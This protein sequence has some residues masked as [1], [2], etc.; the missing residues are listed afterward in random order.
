MTETA[1]YGLRYLSGERKINAIKLVRELTRRG[2]AECKSIVD[3]Q[4][5]FARGLEREAAEAIVARFVSEAGSEIELIEE[6]EH[7]YAFDLR[8]PQ[9]GDQPLVRLRWHGLTLAWERGRLDEWTGEREDSFADAAARDR[10]IAEQRGRWV[11]QGLETVTNELDLVRRTSAREL[12]FEQAIRETGWQEDAAIV[13]ADWLQRQGDPRGIVAALDLARARH[14]NQRE[15]LDRALVE[16]LEQH[17][18]HLFGPLRGIE[19]SVRLQ[20]WAGHVIRIDLDEYIAGH[21]YWRSGNL[22]ALA[23]LLGLPICAC[24]RSLLINSDVIGD[25]GFVSV[26]AGAD[27]LLLAGLRELALSSRY[28]VDTFDEWERMPALERLELLCGPGRSIRLPALRELKLEISEPDAV[29]ETLQTSELPRLRELNLHLDNPMFRGPLREQ[30]SPDVLTELLDLPEIARLHTLVLSHRGE[31]WSRE[32][33]EALLA[34]RGL[35]TVERVDL[36]GLTVDADALERLL[37]EQSER[38]NLL[39]PNR[40]W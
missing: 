7:I 28:V 38:P 13:Y 4:L 40:S 5:E 27:P 24:L 35:R 34:A 25:P 32:I 33:V 9:R 1:T 39:L 22:E 12:G 29:T 30:W 18:S 17:R 31:R 20:W 2:L 19:A 3:Q 37:E 11:E 26:L 23:Q 36:R 6:A 21:R 14:P 8:H 15:Q 10:A 16:A